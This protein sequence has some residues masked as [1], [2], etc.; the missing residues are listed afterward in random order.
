MEYLKLNN[1]R[2]AILHSIILQFAMKYSSKYDGLDIYKFFQIWNPQYL[3][4][5]DKEKQYKDGKT[6]PSLVEKFIRLLIEKNYNF[7]VKYLQ[8]TIK[9]DLLVID[10]I[11]ETY[12]WKLF[13]LHKDNKFHKLWSLFDFYANNFSNFEESHWHSEILKLANRFMVEENSWRFFNFFYFWG[14]RNLRSEDWQDETDGEHTYKPLARKSLSIINKHIKSNDIDTNDL[15]WVL[16]LYNIALKKFEG[17]TW[18]LREYATLLYKVNKVED[19]IAIYK[20]IILDLSDQAYVWHE[21][22]KL[23]E[24]ID[25]NISISMLCKA[26]SIQRNED[27]L[28]QIHLELAKLLK[29]KEFNVEAK[30]ELMLYEKHRNEKGWKLSEEFITLNKQLSEINTSENN[31]AFYANNLELAEEYI[32]S[33]IEWTDLLLF[34]KFKTREQKNRLVFTDLKN[35]ELAINPYKFPLLK[36]SKIDEVYQLKLHYDNSNNKYIALKI[37]KSNLEK[38]DLIDNASSDIAIVDHINHDKKLFHYVVDKSTDGIVKFNQTKIR[39]QAGDFIKIKYFKTFNKNKNEYRTHMLD[40]NKTDKIN[41][42]LLKEVSGEVRLNYKY[43]KIAFGFVD[44]YYIPGFLLE[45]LDIEDDDYIFVK[46]IFNPKEPI[47]K[48]WKVFEVKI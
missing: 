8:N 22:A 4:N 44:D 45:K 9:D 36:N 13:N 28:D 29:Q 38:K 40:I 1:P 6:Y 2:P 37:Q 30:T 26:I 41:S 47:K 5:E 17:D 16:E 25:I 33:D 12:F 15:N 39:P 31:K 48:Q 27:F 32:Y 43:G 18:L 23:L 42:A 10:T 3:R 24:S 19:A 46:M 7:D 21:F 11:R 35:I 20:N 14:Y 34:D